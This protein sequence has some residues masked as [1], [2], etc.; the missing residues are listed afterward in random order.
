VTRALLDTNV[1]ASGV[2]RLHPKAPSVQLLDAWRAGAFELLISDDILAELARTF[3]NRYFSARLT[4]AQVEAALELFTTDATRIRLTSEVQGVASHP[5]DDL[6]LSAAVSGGA[7]YLVTGDTQL[8]SLHS[9]EDIPILSPA[10]FLAI[11]TTET[12]SR[13][14]RPAPL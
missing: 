5:E 11:L 9:F 14:G 4:S 8:R 3:T 6:I 2:G 10:A 13:P 1:L 7:D 12:E